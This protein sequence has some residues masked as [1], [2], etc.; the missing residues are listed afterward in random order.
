MKKIISSLAAL[1]ILFGAQAQEFSSFNPEDYDKEKNYGIFNYIQVT[2]YRGQ[3]LASSDFEDFFSEGFGGVGI[4]FGTQSTGRKEWQRIHNYPQYGV[5]VSSFNL[6]GTDVDS[7]IG[8]PTALYFF[9]GAP[10]ARWGKFRINSDVEIGLST[11]FNAYDSESNPNQDFIGATTNLHFNYTLAFYY[12]LSDRIDISLGASFMHFSNG[13]MFT[14]QRGINLFGLNLSSAYHFNPIKNYTKHVDPTYQPPLRPEFIITENSPFKGHHE[15]TFM[16]SIGTVQAEPGE[17]KDEYGVKDT[18]GTVGPRYM[19]NT[20]TAE[21]AY[22]FAKKLKAVGGLDMFYDG[23]IENNYD[24]I[25]PQNTTYS[26]KSFYG[27]HVGFHYLIERVSLIFNYG[28]YIYKPFEQRGKYFMRA[29]GRIGIT[30]NLDAH[31]AL[32]TRNGGIADWIE[33]GVAYK[34]K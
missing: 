32:K 4:R 28:R 1:L 2:G 21:Y 7:I 11:D 20:I 5:G 18:S 17:W 12:E 30:E 6:G 23:S 9:F 25:L 31:I 3:H 14:P 22:Q 13:R 19:V 34:I 15:F 33:W 27:Y 29:G 26:D 8:K 16:G 24:N 10:M